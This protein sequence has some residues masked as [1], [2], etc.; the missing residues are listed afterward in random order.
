MPIVSSK[1]V[2][3]G[4]LLYMVAVTA[5]LFYF[6]GQWEMQRGRA[7]AAERALY[8]LCADI[9]D[10]APQ[11]VKE[12]APKPLAFP[13]PGDAAALGKLGVQHVCSG[14]EFAEAF[15]SSHR[16]PQSDAR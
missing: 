7:R 9:R 8:W 14:D 3:T 16:E 2:S 6:V 4:M 12:T 10:A 13:S 1:P 15:V 5:G 11:L